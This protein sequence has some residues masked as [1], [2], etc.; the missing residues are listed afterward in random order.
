MKTDGLPLPSAGSCQMSLL[1]S[2]SAPGNA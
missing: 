1:A 2:V